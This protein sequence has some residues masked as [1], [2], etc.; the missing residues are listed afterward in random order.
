MKIKIIFARILL[1]CS[2][3]SVS[4]TIVLP[5]YKKSIGQMILP[6][7]N[8]TYSVVALCVCLGFFFYIAKRIDNDI[9]V[10]RLKLLLSCSFLLSLLTNIAFM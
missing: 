3:V 6:A 1:L 9:W 4:T 10:N 7:F 5:I 2:I 8:G